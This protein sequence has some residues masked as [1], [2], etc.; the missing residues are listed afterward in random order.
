VRDAT[1]DLA[2]SLHG[3]A[4]DLRFRFSLTTLTEDG[5]AFTLFKEIEPALS[6]VDFGSKPEG[7]AIAID[8]VTDWTEHQAKEIVGTTRTLRASGVLLYEQGVWVFD[9]WQTPTGAVTDRTLQV[10]VPLTGATHIAHHVDDR[11]AL[12]G[13]LPVITR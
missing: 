11:P 10:T 4:W 6:F 3:G 8:G 9:H 13:L 5:Q 2:D 1:I 12:L 7:A